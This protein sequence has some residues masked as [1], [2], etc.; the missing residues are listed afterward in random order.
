MNDAHASSGKVLFDMDFRIVSTFG[1]KS[2]RYPPAAAYAQKIR[3]SMKQT[4]YMRLIQ[5][6]QSLRIAKSPVAPNNTKSKFVCVLIVSSLVEEVCFKT[7]DCH[8]P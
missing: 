6:R 8:H 3:P 4:G 1:Q 2:R 5:A 7:F